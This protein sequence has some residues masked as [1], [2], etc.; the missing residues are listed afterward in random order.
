MCQ[1]MLARFLTVFPDMD[2]KNRHQYEL[3]CIP[4]DVYSGVVDSVPR[5]QQNTI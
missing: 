2:E 5:E 1:T 4:Y 3:S